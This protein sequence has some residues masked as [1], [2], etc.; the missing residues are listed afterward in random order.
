MSTENETPM[1]FEDHAEALG[2]PAPVVAA[3]TRAYDWP[4]GKVL[5]RSEYCTAVDQTMN[6]EASVGRGALA[7]TTEPTEPT[8]HQAG[9][10]PNRAT[11]VDNT[12]G[13]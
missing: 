5:T 10:Y 12:E 6:A 2:T 1:P 4:V 9:H 7:P 11:A 3:V 8:E 13:N